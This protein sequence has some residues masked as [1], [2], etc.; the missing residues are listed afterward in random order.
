MKC[1]WIA[2]HS[3]EFPVAVLCRFMAIS[4]SRYYDWLNAPKTEREQENEQLR[5]ILTAL[6]QKRRGTYGTRRL[7]REYAKLGYVV[8]RRR[9]G[10]L[11]TQAG[12]VCKTKKKFKATTDSKHNKPMAPNLLD[13]QF[14]VSQPDRYYV[15]DMTYVATEEGWLYLAAVI[16]L[17]S[18]KVVDWSMDSRM[19]AKLVNDALLMALWKRKHENGLIWHTDRGSRYASDSHRVI[20]KEHQVV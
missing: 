19:K 5:E 15:G 2:K 1:A 18:R 17:F 3:N 6:F 14:T 4:R 7:K 8:S 12:P 16:D 11:M 9:I 10:R 13:R 20:L